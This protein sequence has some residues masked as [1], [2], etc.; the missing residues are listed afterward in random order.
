MF[1]ILLRIGSTIVYS[2]TV[3]LVVGMVA[4]MI[5]CYRWARER[6][7]DPNV[8]LDAG[9]W[10]LLGGI[11][12]GR[13]GYVL[14]NWAYY[15]D[16]LNRALNLREGGLAWHG[17]LIGGG[18]AVVLWY[19]IR[20]RRDRAL[21]DWRDLA[22]SAAPGLAL[23]GAFGWLGALLT[24]SAY[25]REASGYAPPLS[26]LAADL[27]DIYGV[28]AMR[29]VT[30]PLMIVW[31][32]ALWGV[33]WGLRRQLARGATFALYLLLY[34]LGDF[35]VAFLRGDGMWRLGLWLWQWVALAEMCAGIG[36]AVHIW[37]RADRTMAEWAPS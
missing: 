12:G 23:G 30:Q 17:A 18:M 1:P 4:G 2:Y 15:V 36:L 28:S 5:I 20:Q 14:A 9:F 37:F 11:L 6:L 35:V 32:L 13:A 19:A 7:P 16:H 31:C 26:W 33:L 10:A 27:P 34:A 24:G 8:V 29:L 25:G 3:A 22:D 21:P